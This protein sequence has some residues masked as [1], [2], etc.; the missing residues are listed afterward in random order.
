MAF[1][2]AFVL[3]EEFADFGEFLRRDAAGVEG[4]H[5]EV[6]GGAAKA[7]LDEIVEEV[8]LGLFLGLGGGVDL[9]ALGVVFEEEAFVGHDLDHFEGGG[10]AGVGAV[11]EECVVDL[12]YG[13]GAD[14][15]EDAEDGEFD[16]GGD[17]G[18]GAGHGGLGKD[19]RRK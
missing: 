17:G 4:A 5:D 13:G 8:K 14:V 12:S 7:A 11:W 6:H 9:G 16:V 2:R 3:R 15:P 1:S 18:G 10:V 19:E